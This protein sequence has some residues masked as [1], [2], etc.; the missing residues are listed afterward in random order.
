MSGEEG[1]EDSELTDVIS[2]EVLK[3]F[4]NLLIRLAG[5]QV[6]REWC[7]KPSPTRVNPEGLV[8]K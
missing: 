5:A 1:L 3:V 6:S 2:A 4:K 7:A 8:E